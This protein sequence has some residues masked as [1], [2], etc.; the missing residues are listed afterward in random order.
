MLPDGLIE[1][2]C[3]IDPAASVAWSAKSLWLYMFDLLMVS[4]LIK[5]QNSDHVEQSAQLWV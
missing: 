2:E 3:Y 4:L 1:T 5:T